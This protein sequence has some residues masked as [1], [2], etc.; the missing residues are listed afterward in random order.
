MRENRFKLPGTEAGVGAVVDKQM[1]SGNGRM[2]TRAEQ[3][4]YSHPE[5]Y[6]KKCPARNPSPKTAYINA[7]RPY[8]F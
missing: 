5:D 8:S 1:S 4:R 2:D 7:A 3:N 6:Q